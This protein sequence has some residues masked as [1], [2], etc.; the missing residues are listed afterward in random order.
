M[1]TSSMNCLPSEVTI[2]TFELGRGNNWPKEKG[3]DLKEGRKRE[4]GGKDRIIS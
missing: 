1:T 3:G 2:I 4:G